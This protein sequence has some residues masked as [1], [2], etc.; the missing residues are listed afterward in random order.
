MKMSPWRSQGV[1]QTGVAVVQGDA[2]V[3]SLIELNLGASEAEAAGL[4]GDLKAKA[5]PLYDIVVTLRRAHER[6]SRC[7]RDCQVPDAKRD[8][9]GAPSSGEA[10]VV[11][12]D[13]W[14]Q[15]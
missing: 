2:T 5:F 10:T 13:E 12:G 15:D 6:S 8:R 3:K 9:F 1:L 11:V 4:L 14:L 7:G